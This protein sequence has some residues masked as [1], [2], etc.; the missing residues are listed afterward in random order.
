MRHTLNREYSTVKKKKTIFVLCNKM[1]GTGGNYTQSSKEGNEGQLQ[2]I[3]LQYGIQRTKTD[4]LGK[5]RQINRPC[6]YDLGRVLGAQNL[7]D[8]RGGVNHYPITNENVINKKQE[9]EKAENSKQQD[10]A[11]LT[12]GTQNRQHVLPGFIS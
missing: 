4:E 10:M 7:G 3:T 1:D 6:I 11:L 8:R 12:G 9:K 2:L 5:R